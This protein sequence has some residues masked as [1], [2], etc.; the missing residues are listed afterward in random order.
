M[1]AAGLYTYMG[2]DPPDESD[3]WDGRPRENVFTNNVVSDT[4]NG[5]K[6]NEGDENVFTCESTRSTFTGIVPFLAVVE[7]FHSREGSH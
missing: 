3:S 5:V 4:V 7:K 1:P 6:I 2:S